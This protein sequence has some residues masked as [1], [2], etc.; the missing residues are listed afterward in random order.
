MQQLN[1]KVAVVTGAGA[2][3]GYATAKRF[4]DEGAF[5][6]ITGLDQDE[7]DRAA[8]EIGP[9]VYP[10]RADSSNLLDLDRLYEGVRSR[11]GRVDVVFANAGKGELMP[12]GDVTEDHFDRAF[13]LNVKGVLFTVKKALPL[14]PD[15]GSIILPSSVMNSMGMEGFSVYAATKAAVRN[16]ARNWAIDLKARKIRVN[17]IAP[18]PI[19]TPGLLA[20]VSTQEQ[21]QALLAGFAAGIP[22]GRVGQPDD[23][24]KVAVFLASDASAFING[25][26]IVADGGFLQT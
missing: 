19:E 2:G 3:I 9:N 4:A 15:G 13:N 17:A 21:R 10:V 16:F 1:G 7:L 14:M 23:I 5:V 26:E 11:K 6:F 20:L 25:A 24:A 22:L 8:D 18:G 12:L